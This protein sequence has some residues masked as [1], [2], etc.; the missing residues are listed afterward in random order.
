MSEPTGPRV[1][2]LGSGEP[3]RELT[4]ALRHLGAEVIA[5]DDDVADADR[6]GCRPSWQGWNP[7]SW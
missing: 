2:L 5:V 3:S 6:R 7:I 4:T 1:M